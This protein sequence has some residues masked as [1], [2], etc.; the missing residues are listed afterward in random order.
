MGSVHAFGPGQVQQVR[1]YFRLDPLRL[2][3]LLR[4]SDDYGRVE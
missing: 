3:R 4:L 2:L 1:A